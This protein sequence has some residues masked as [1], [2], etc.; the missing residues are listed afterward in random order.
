M[1]NESTP[2]KDALQKL[3][4]DPITDSAEIGVLGSAADGVGIRARVSTTLGKGWSVAADG[5]WVHRTG[6]SVAAAARW[7][8]G[9]SKGK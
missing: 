9:K 5:S 7:S 4:T 1:S 3:E 2:I 6:W 8:K